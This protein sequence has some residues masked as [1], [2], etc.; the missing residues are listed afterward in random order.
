MNISIFNVLRIS[1]SNGELYNII[2]NQAANGKK[3]SL[4]AM[5][6]GQK[7]RAE[8]LFH[9]YTAI[10]EAS[11]V[12][13]QLTHIY[14]KTTDKRITIPKLAHWYNRAEGMNLKLFNSEIKT[15]QNNYVIIANYFD[16]R[17]TNVSAKSFNAKIKAFRSQFKGV[18][19]IP[20]FI[21]RLSKIFA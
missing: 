17:S 18:R 10:E 5:M 19:G 3:G 2:T 12:S 4:I 6:Q 14:N 8:I 13:M 16:N 21:F 9:E 1:L 20:Y 11:V 7:W 15:M